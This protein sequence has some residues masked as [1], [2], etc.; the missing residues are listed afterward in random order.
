MTDPVQ[1]RSD[2]ADKLNKVARPYLTILIT[3]IYNATLLIAL[4]KGLLEVKEYI[5]AIGPVNSMVM[6]FWFGER[7]ALKV[8]GKDNEGETG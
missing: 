4:W 7:A 8:P 1:P 6:G 3:T 5:L 2:W